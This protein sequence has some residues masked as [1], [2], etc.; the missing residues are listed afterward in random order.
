[1]ATTV[2][3]KKM[4]FSNRSEELPLQ[5]FPTSIKAGLDSLGMKQWHFRISDILKNLRRMSDV[6][7]NVTPT[8]WGK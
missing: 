8:E 1:M 7:D 2:T 4:E 3:A 5:L 6:Q